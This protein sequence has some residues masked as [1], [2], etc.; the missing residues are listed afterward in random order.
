MTLLMHSLPGP[1]SHLGMEMAMAFSER[2]RGAPP[3]FLFLLPNMQN[4]LSFPRSVSRL[5]VLKHAS[6]RK[7]H[8][9]V[10]SQP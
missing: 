2:R 5:P 6:R 8:L 1:R 10:K 3:V 9:S 4:P 7:H